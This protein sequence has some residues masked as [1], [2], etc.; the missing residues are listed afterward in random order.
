[1][2]LCDEC[3]GRVTPGKDEAEHKCPANRHDNLRLD[4]AAKL[5]ELTDEYADIGFDREHIADCMQLWVGQQY[6]DR[7]STRVIAVG[8]LKRSNSSASDSPSKRSK[9]DPAKAAE[10]AEESASS[11][12]SSEEEE[13]ESSSS[14]DGAE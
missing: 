2:L 14:Q 3:W 10:A 8:G 7:V 12:S 4:L 9:E 1:M 6:Q 13:D 5:T 11:S